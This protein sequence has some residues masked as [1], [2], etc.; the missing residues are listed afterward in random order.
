[1]IPQKEKILGGL[2]GAAIGDA[3]GALTETY[4]PAMIKEVYG[5]YITDFETPAP[6][7]LCSGTEGGMVTDDFSC[8]YYTAEEMLAAQ[9]DITKE[10]AEKA[11]HIAADI[12]VFTNH[13][14]IVEET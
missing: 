6:D 14:V 9:S 2:L 4:T 1:M 5:H 8:A 11:L 12:C 10:I 7:I 3:L 13:N